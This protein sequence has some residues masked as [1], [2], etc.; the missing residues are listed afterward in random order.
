VQ[1]FSRSNSVHLVMHTMIANLTVEC[2][3]EDADE[4]VPSKLHGTDELT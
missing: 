4:R 1:R 3:R 2:T